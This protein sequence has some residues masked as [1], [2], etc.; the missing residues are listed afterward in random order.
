M[1]K[2]EIQVPALGE[3]ITEATVAKWFIKKGEHIK[4]DAVILELETDKVS[5]EIYASESGILENI[6]FQEGED[7]NIGD[8][9]GVIDPTSEEATD[10]DQEK[11]KII[12]NKNNNNKNSI[13]E[14]IVPSL[15]ESITEAVIGK[16]IKS[17]G[18]EVAKGE[19]LVEIETDKVT[20]ELYAEDNGVIKE[21][22]YQEQ[23]EVKIGEIIARIELK[24]DLENLKKVAS[25]ES[26]EEKG[27][28]AIDQIA[29]EEK[30][31]PEILNSDLDPTA[32]KRT[33]IGN[34]VTLLD[35]VEFS[36]DLSF[37]PSAKKTIREKSKNI[38]NTISLQ[39]SNIIT[40]SDALNNIQALGKSEN[41]ILNEQSEKTD[42]EKP[43]S[44][45]RQSIAS[46]LKQAQN[47]AAMLTTF[48]EIDMFKIISIRNK[49]KDRFLEKYGVKLGFMSIFTKAAITVLKEIPDI[50]AEIKGN[51]IIYKNRYDI[52]IAVGTE[53]G[54]YVPVIRNADEMSFSNIE[55]EIIK[56][57]KMAK[58]NKLTLDHMKDGTFT[59]SNGGV[60]GSMLSTPILNTPQSGILGLH[61]IVKRPWVVND[62]IEIRPIMY[63]ALTYDHRIV[64][65]KEAVTFLVRLKEI[66]ENPEQMMFD[67]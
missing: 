22:L 12:E 40:Q 61:N 24:S 19:P 16:W 13:K 56:Y 62:Q 39:N 50:N 11:E 46:R 51:S 9:L 17:V 48:N 14:V 55:G 57:G 63:V 58:E 26:K 28:S 35:L 59:I 3:S 37:S 49:Y 31:K 43:L 10:T 64:D 1:K 41:A 33:G 42:V 20:Q 21:C 32:V 67:L 47:T 44:K 8:T 27:A 52:G 23:E 45:L 4:K 6:F 29:K 30:L 7:V 53:R 15:G 25:T 65:G 2:I 54:L 66:I 38:H 5:Q 34:K 18:Q 60:Y 36:N